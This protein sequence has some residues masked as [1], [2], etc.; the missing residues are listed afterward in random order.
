MPLHYKRL[1]MYRKSLWITVNGRI[2]DAM[3]NYSYRIGPFS[4]QP[5]WGQFNA[6]MNPLSVSR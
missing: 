2:C 5:H 4:P 1:I 3:K 6:V